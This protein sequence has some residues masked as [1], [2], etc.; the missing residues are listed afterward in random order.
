[1]MHRDVGDE[2]RSDPH[3]GGLSATLFRSETPAGLSHGR[4]FS[5]LVFP[6][7]P[8]CVRNV[9][10][11]SSE[12]TPTHKQGAF[13]GI[14]RSQAAKSGTRLAPDL[15]CA[16][17]DTGTDCGR[18]R[19]R[20]VFVFSGNG[21]QGSAAK[22]ILVGG[23]EDRLTETRSNLAGSQGIRSGAGTGGRPV[24]CSYPCCSNGGCGYARL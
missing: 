9:K 23:L 3:R 16:N 5:M 20:Q 11:R 13:S 17:L 18:R 24:R 14:E 12:N 7:S 4:N 6:K 15:A 21:G 1:M 19:D 10:C 22:K 2:E 8:I